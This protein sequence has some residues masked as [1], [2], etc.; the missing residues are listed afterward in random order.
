M[1]IQYTR[2]P[3][4]NR[5]LWILA[6]LTLAHLRFLSEPKRF[7]SLFE[8]IRTTKSNISNCYRICSANFAIGIFHWFRCDYL[9]QLHRLAVFAPVTDWQ[10]QAVFGRPTVLKSGNANRILAQNALEISN[11][12]WKWEPADVRVR[13]LT[14][15]N[16]ALVYAYGRDLNGHWSAT[17]GLQ[18]ALALNEFTANRNC[19]QTMIWILIFEQKRLRVQQLI[20]CSFFTCF[21][22]GWNRI[23]KKFSSKKMIVWFS[24]DI[25]EWTKSIFAILWI[26]RWNWINFDMAV[27]YNFFEIELNL[28]VRWH[29]YIND[30]RVNLVDERK[31]VSWPQ[32]VTETNLVCFCQKIGWKRK[33]YTIAV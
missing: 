5:E 9:G 31:A 1:I 7:E 20:Q 22:F 3:S 10:W 6:N 26:L 32:L 11:N 18:L 12:F 28:A 23:E 30:V 27:N 33:F 24:I 8:S 29:E 25:N 14:C 19:T 21:A 17:N 15:D 16:S 2:I 4:I 13:A